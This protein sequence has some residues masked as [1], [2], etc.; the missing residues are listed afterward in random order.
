[1]TDLRQAA[2]MALEALTTFEK[3]S[4]H[5]HL[6]IYETITIPEAINAIQQALAEP[7]VTNAEPVAWM[8]DSK[9]KGNGKQ[10]HWTKAQALKWTSNITP[11]YAAPLKR[12]WVGLTDEEIERD[13]YF[14]FDY[15][16]FA[17]AIEAK[18]REKNK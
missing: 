9:T 13:H 17:R 15:R 11:L 6:H 18:L 5:E 7:P 16:K 1:M 4:S 3:I 8:S 10:L 12:E 14:P 2:E